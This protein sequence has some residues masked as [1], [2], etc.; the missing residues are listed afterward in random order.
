MRPYNDTTNLDGLVQMYEEEIGA[1]PGFVSGSTTRLKRFA[2][3]TKTAWNRYLSLALSASGK[4][5]YD[6][7]NHSDYPIIEGD[8]IAN[9]RDVTFTNDESGNLILDVYRVFV[10]D[11]AGVYQEVFPVDEQSGHGMDDFTDGQDRTGTPTFYDKTGNGIRFNVLP[12][13]NW[14]NTEEGER[15]VKIYINRTPSYFTYTDTSK[16]PGCPAVHHDYF[17]LRPAMDYARQKGLET[18]DQLRL[19]VLA[20]EGVP[21]R[22]VAGSIERHFSRR[23]KDERNVMTGKRSLFI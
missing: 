22:G 17:Y 18:Y 10:K 5:Q 7:S 8:L 4:W 6:D 1:E 19:E 11:P 13:Y 15:G 9:Q 2:S 3:Q 21:E 23:A 20:Y 16:N 14:R 12:N